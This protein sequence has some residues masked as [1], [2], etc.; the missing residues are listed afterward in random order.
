[1]PKT[2]SKR[3]SKQ[4]V[5]CYTPT[6]VFDFFN[7]ESDYNTIGIGYLPDFLIID[8]ILSMR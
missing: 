1:M 2:N 8:F 7:G 4:R 6:V 3:Y 5:F